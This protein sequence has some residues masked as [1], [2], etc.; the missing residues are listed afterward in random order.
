VVVLVRVNALAEYES[1]ISFAEV[2]V[3]APPPLTL[4]SFSMNLP[5]Q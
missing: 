1:V 4:L 2:E 3:I 5:M